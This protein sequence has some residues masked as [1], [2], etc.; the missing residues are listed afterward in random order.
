MIGEPIIEI[1]GVEKALGESFPLRITDFTLRE[2]E[3]VVLS[4]LP[5]VMGEALMNMIIGATLPDEGDVIV[6]GTNTRDIRTD[7]EWLKSLDRFGLVS[8]RAVLLDQ[9]TVAQNLALPVTLAIDP[10]APD[11]RAAVEAVA[12]EVG[13][14]L[15]RLDQ[16]MGPVT[17]ADPIERVRIHLARALANRPEVLLLEHPTR[18]FGPGSSAFGAQLRSIADARK[19]SLI[20]VSDDDVFARETGARRYRVERDGAVVP[21]GAGLRGWL[22]RLWGG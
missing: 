16:P 2:H 7:T 20:A 14:P 17:D 22:P 8:N 1:R 19:L 5:G 15:G 12:T 18:G 4:G 11:V 6:F 13:V 9:S 21:A 10:M 3:R